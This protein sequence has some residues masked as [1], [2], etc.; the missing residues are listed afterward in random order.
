[1]SFVKKEEQ[2]IQYLHV[3][4]GTWYFLEAYKFGEATKLLQTW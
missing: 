1:M 2:Y 3:F 4:L